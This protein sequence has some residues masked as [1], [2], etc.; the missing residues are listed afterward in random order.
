MKLKYLFLIGNGTVFPNCHCL[1]CDSVNL[2]V[3]FTL[4]MIKKMQGYGLNVHAKI[5]YEISKMF[6][7]TL[8]LYGLIYTSPA[9]VARPSTIK[10]NI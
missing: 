7:D 5:A 8:T 4:I 3:V 10:I 9:T 2:N 6:G 1:D